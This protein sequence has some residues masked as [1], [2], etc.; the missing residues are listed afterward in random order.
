MLLEP[1][2]ESSVTETD[3]PLAVL[4]SYLCEL[5]NAAPLAPVTVVV[6]SSM[7]ASA[8]RHQL[9]KKFGGLC[10]VSFTTP[11]NLAHR[12]GVIAARAPAATTVG[13]LKLDSHLRVV[14]A[15][16]SKSAGE[17]TTQGG[18]VA[19]DAGLI[20]ALSSS[21]FELASLGVE[22]PI[23]SATDPKARLA[24]SA[25]VEVRKYLEREGQCL[26]IDNFS[27]A[28]EVLAGA[29]GES[30][31]RKLGKVVLFAP[32]NL[33]HAAATMFSALADVEG[34]FIVHA[35]TGISA[36]DERFRRTLSFDW[37]DSAVVLA[38]RFVE[39]APG[40]PNTTIVHTPDR[41]SEIEVAIAE[42]VK[43][44][45]EGLALDEMAIL[46][47][48]REVYLAELLR[49]ADRALI[50]VNSQHQ[51]SLVIHRELEIFRKLVRFCQSG[52]RRDLVELA[53][54]CD[55][56]AARIGLA[57]QLVEEATVVAELSGDLFYW[58]EHSSG[59]GDDDLG[60]VPYDKVIGAEKQ[61]ILQA[62]A[63]FL[64]PLQAS[65]VA[66]EDSMRTGS[67]RDAVLAA[68]GLFA[69]VVSGLPLLFEQEASDL[70]DE[71][72]QH[73]G[74]DF[75]AALRSLLV[76]ETGS[77]QVSEGAFWM[78]MDAAMP[79]AR[80]ASSQDARGV[81]IA[82]VDSFLPMTSKK[83]ICIGLTDDLFPSRA[84][85]GFLTEAIRRKLGLMGAPDRIAIAE[86]AFYTQ[87]R[88]ARELV[89]C[90]ARST[91]GESDGLY[92]SAVLGDLE[93]RIAASGA[94]ARHIVVGSRGDFARGVT[95]PNDLEMLNRANLLAN[96][97]FGV[98]YEYRDH[99]Q[100]Q[101]KP[102]L[103]LD[104][105]AKTLFFA[106][107]RISSDAASIP[108]TLSPT[109]IENYLSCPYRFFGD[110]M[111]GIRDLGEPEELLGLDSLERGSL[112]HRIFEA[113][114]KRQMESPAEVLSFDIS[115]FSEL[116]EG[117]VAVASRA[118]RD[119]SKLR[120]FWLERDL[121]RIRREVAEFLQQAHSYH[122][123]DQVTTIGVEIE[124]RAE[125][126]MADPFDGKMEVLL[127]GKLDRV[128]STSAGIKIVDYKTGNYLPYRRTGG[129]LNP[130]KVQLG[131]Y[132]VMLRDS[133]LVR[134][135]DRR[136]E[137]SGM[138]WF[139]SEKYGYR[140]QRADHE[141]LGELADGAAL[142][143][144]LIRRGIFFPGLHA[145]G[146]SRGCDYC[147]PYRGFDDS[148]RRSLAE[149][150][151]ANSLGDGGDVPLELDFWSRLL[152]QV[153]AQGGL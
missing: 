3:P 141:A 35:E 60:E 47:S 73:V 107:L 48:D 93:R 122:I 43:G 64:L 110:K 80:D 137:L 71:D 32:H 36:L 33:A 20:K 95:V 109:A 91:V 82:S 142:A 96:A 88:Y 100:F 46:V 119:S 133:S 51:P 67:W 29:Q 30:V 85:E 128:D 116:V 17:K 54:T 102:L 41:K 69:H 101:A 44:A 127:Q 53:A 15:E 79:M 28:A 77:E 149:F 24:I 118:L 131:I 143:V 139:V 115:D 14:L 86:R 40:W 104:Q 65:A 66:F 34:L 151:G 145:V 103:R 152:E 16:L 117:A 21:V 37:D 76:L 49:A 130:H 31:A 108:M 4:G 26:E 132:A 99:G 25:F 11:L 7:A 138:Y 2:T 111:L 92:P 90:V 56:R 106:P 55:L 134:H 97:D 18:I 114:V 68:W 120:R 22:V 62:L 84:A 74:A 9:A 123:S 6:G 45:E 89:V 105:A 125:V 57:S 126:A 136:S 124:V 140:H 83:L 5:K 70:G 146:A 113:I 144:A 50:P 147:D 72:S 94:I 153:G 150:L 61:R 135:G 8:I 59:G 121:A 12:I 98:A 27:Y 87:V 58:A 38:S 23:A 81:R 112:L 10:N 75:V 13:R 19:P 148:R 78:A 129:G 39:V 52:Q 63:R 42:I 1:G